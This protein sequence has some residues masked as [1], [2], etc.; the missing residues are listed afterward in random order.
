[1]SFDYNGFE[2]AKVPRY[3]KMY[4]RFG[5]LRALEETKRPGRVLFAHRVARKL[6]GLVAYLRGFVE[7]GEVG[8]IHGLCD[9]H[10]RL[11]CFL[12][13]VFLPSLWENACSTVIR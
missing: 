9:F 13:G 12:L 10:H 1:M 5:L 6:N 7:R 3:T 4:L 11:H 8:L 2:G